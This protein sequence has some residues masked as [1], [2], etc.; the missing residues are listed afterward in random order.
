MSELVAPAVR[1]LLRGGGDLINGQR[2][3]QVFRAAALVREASTMD[4]AVEFLCGCRAN[5][6]HCIQLVLTLAV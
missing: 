6:A 5:L 1:I 4:D 3:I 2:H